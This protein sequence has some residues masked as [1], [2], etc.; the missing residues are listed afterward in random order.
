M[1][2]KEEKIQILANSLEQCEVRLKQDSSN[3][4]LQIIK[5]VIEEIM[6]VTLGESNASPEMEENNKIGLFAVREFEP[7]DMEF[8]NSI[9]KVIEV[10]NE[11]RK[12]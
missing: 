1:T 10:N 2:S 6:S 8:A 5:E 12:T 7:H 9:Y 11:L 4:P 3:R